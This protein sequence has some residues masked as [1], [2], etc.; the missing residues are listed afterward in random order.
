[1]VG[2]P[3]LSYGEVGKAPLYLS[4]LSSLAPLLHCGLVGISLAPYPRNSHCRGFDWLK[5]LMLE[6]T[7]GWTPTV[8]FF[9]FSFFFFSFLTFLLDP[10]ILELRITKEGYPVYKYKSLIREE[11]PNNSISAAAGNTS[12]TWIGHRLWRTLETGPPG[13][14]NVILSWSALLTEK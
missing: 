7:R 4:K 13:Q 6:P 9:L 2:T 1:M 10:L 8:L 11:S 14:L 5:K 12:M 3:G